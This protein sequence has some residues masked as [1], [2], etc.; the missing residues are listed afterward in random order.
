MSKN[1]NASFQ[2]F[3]SIFFLGTDIDLQILHR[4]SSALECTF[5]LLL[6]KLF[7]PYLIFQ[8]RLHPDIVG[9]LTRQNLNK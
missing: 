7:I 2:I 3:D 5:I 4:S 6:T 1:L 9:L 8:L